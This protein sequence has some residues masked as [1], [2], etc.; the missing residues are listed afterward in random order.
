MLYHKKAK[1]A[2]FFCTK[3]SLISAGSEKSKKKSRVF[4]TFFYFF[5]FYTI[6]LNPDF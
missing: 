4:F 1:K 5:A 3:K 6:F 2:N